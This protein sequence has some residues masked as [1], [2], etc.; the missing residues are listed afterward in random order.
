MKK[1][2]IEWQVYRND[3]NINF[4]PR[5]NASTKVLNFI[6]RYKTW[7][8]LNI[9]VGDILKDQRRVNSPLNT[10]SSSLFIII[11]SLHAN[12]NVQYRRLEKIRSNEEPLG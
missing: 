2:D 11:I 8:E 4:V 9:S 10:N 6:N 12:K 7:L 5:E 3:F 1:S